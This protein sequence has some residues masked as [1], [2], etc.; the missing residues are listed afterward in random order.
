MI[1][2]NNTGHRNEK[3]E[4]TAYGIFALTQE[5][6]QRLPKAKILLLGIF[7]REATV[8]DPLRKLNEGV[9]NIIK[10]Y[11][12]NK[13][14]YYLNINKAFLDVDGNLSKEVMPDLLHPNAIGYQIW[15]D[16]MLPTIKEL[17][18]M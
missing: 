4:D 8:D 11:A 7:P 18:A 12:D 15:A 13:G 16:S 3:S 10:N 6:R 1:G 17:M 14:I 5:I 2:T 9:N